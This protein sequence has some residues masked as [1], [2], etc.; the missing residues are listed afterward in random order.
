[1]FCP[2]C[3]CETGLHDSLYKIGREV[4]AHCSGCG[5][6]WR[7]SGTP[8]VAELERRL[9]AVPGTKAKHESLL[10]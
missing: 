4:L 1:M 7:S 9:A 6:C 8:F 2:S 3:G 5:P 10:K